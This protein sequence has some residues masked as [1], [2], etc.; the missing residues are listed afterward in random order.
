MTEAEF[1][2]AHQLVAH[3][4]WRWMGGMR[5]EHSCGP[6][7]WWPYRVCGDQTVMPRAWVPTLSDPATQGCLWAMLRESEPYDGIEQ[8]HHA[9]HPPKWLV[10][11]HACSERPSEA[12]AS[13]LLVA[14][15]EP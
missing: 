7:R 10:G 8:V 11:P 6:D 15:G 5:A 1:Y 9:P 3:P 13:A 14:W 12:L 2:L 4:R